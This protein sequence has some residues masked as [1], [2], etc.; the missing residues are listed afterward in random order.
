MLTPVSNKPIGVSIMWVC[1]SDGFLSIVEP[2]GD[3]SKLLVR[4][5]RRGDIERVFPDAAVERTPGRD[6]L[7]RALIDR[8]AV[9]EAMAAQVRG[10]GYSNFKNSVKS[11]PLHDA[12]MRVWHIMASLQDIPPYA[13]NRR[14]GDRL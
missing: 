6:Y 7:F 9:A 5:R 11:R 1:L 8:E 2:Q 3:L 14:Q 4:A 13:A 10:I 12:L